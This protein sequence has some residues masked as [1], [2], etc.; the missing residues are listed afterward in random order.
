[1]WFESIGVDLVEIDVAT[2]V[3]QRNSGSIHCT[4]GRLMKDSEPKSY[5]IFYNDEFMHANALSL[6]KYSLS[7]S[8]FS[9]EL[10]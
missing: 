7:S 6:L 2:L 4:A 5:K 3:R 1:M 9:T 10:V 8:S